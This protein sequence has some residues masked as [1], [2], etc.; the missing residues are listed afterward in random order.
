MV[1]RWN[2]SHEITQGNKGQSKDTW[3]TTFK[4]KSKERKKLGENVPGVGGN[5]ENV[6]HCRRQGRRRISNVAE[7][8]S[9]IRI[10]R[11]DTMRLL[12]LVE[13]EDSGRR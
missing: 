12:W 4:R 6:V 13:S 1:C 7:R 3:E 11:R 9:V 10:E 2:R 8:L 5:Q